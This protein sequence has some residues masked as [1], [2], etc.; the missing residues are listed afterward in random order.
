MA[1]VN[2]ATLTAK[3]NADTTGLKRGLRDAD[4]DVKGFSS[5]SSAAFSKFGVAAAAAGVA[6]AAAVGAFAVK[7][8]SA[9]ADFEKGMNEVFTLIPDASE[10][11]M[12]QMSDDV[13]QFSKD[14]GVLP[15]KV[16]P[17]LYQSLSAG[18]PKDNVFAFMEVATKAAIGGATEL[19]TAVDG[20]TST[21]NAYGAENITAMEAS[22]LMFTAVRLGKTTMDELSQS[23]FQVNPVAA[24]MGVQFGDITA[25]LATM[26]AQGTPTRVATTQLRQAIVE[27][28]KEGT[29]AFDAFQEATGQTFP[30]FIAGGGTME[31]AFQAMK[32]KADDMGVGVGDLFGSVEAGMGVISLT[33]ESGAEAFGKAMD[34]MQES[35]GATDTAFD[36]MDQGLARTWDKI[37]ANVQVALL[38]IGERLAPF[39]ERFATWF[40]DVLPAAIDTLISGVETAVEWIGHFIRGIQSV[41]DWAKNLP[42]PL[43]NVAVG[44]AAVGTA[45]A[46][47]YAN[48]V[49]AGLGVA[50]AAVAL[51]GKMAGDAER[52]ARDLED[53]LLDVGG[54]GSV[55]ENVASAL[56][57]VYNESEIVRNSMSALGVSLA[58]VEWAVRGGPAAFD[59]WT[60]SL[61]DSAA[62]GARSEQQIQELETKLAPLAEG[63]WDLE[64]ASR[65]AMARYESHIAGAA[66]RTGKSQKEII[67]DYEEM[68]ANIRH[69]LDE[70]G[71]SIEEFMGTV[72]DSTD[73]TGDILSRSE[74]DFD[75]WERELGGAAAVAAG[76]MMEATS[77]IVSLWSGAA[78][79]IEISVEDM[80]ANILETSAQ[81]AEMERVYR[82]LMNAG[83]TGLASEL[84][85]KGPAA[86]AAIEEFAFG[87]AVSAADVFHANFLLDPMG[88]MAAL[89]SGNA[90]ARA[91]RAGLTLGEAT[92]AGFVGGF[93]K[94]K[95]NV[96]SSGA[97]AGWNGGDDMIPTDYATGGIVTSETFARIGEGGE[98]DAVIPLSRADEFGFGG[99]SGVTVYVEGNLFGAATVDDLAAILTDAQYGQGRRGW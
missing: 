94:V 37:K 6:A 78:D 63:Y 81:K 46:L 70:S 75:R 49:I 54:V 87:S 10:D 72:D 86:T 16:V 76:A 13:K 53:A 80:M 74:A 88:G 96:D 67:G 52:K 84:A 93:G 90:T 83:L 50:A 4:R 33:S 65:D 30:D 59:Q 60:A 3:L 1:G 19:E 18:V 92:A 15:D 27:L 55:G 40:N 62:A 57:G 31:D 69:Y 11:A 9:F 85:E 7:S 68:Q 14:F 12:D 95:V 42:G 23:L 17:A 82:E 24:A 97:T 5:K 64:K 66:R 73:E 61:R 26:T 91:W 32:D 45:L 22:D 35:S 36:Q 77:T 8:V 47:L 39:V 29:V 34:E 98:P 2:V 51:I 41:V 71:V 43:S 28:G 58:D 56:R 38:E 21:V 44:V 79:D 20:L 99:G 48:P 89:D 25:A